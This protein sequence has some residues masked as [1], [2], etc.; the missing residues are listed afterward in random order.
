MALP[1]RPGSLLVA[2]RGKILAVKTPRRCLSGAANER[3]LAERVSPLAQE[4]EVTG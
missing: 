3:C 2:F 4:E 1:G